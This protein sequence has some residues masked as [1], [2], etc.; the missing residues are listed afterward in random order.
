MKMMKNVLIIT[1]IPETIEGFLLPFVEYFQ[2][3][4]WQL[5]G[6]AHNISNRTRC[7]NIFDRV[8]DIEWSRN[9]LDPRNLLMA[10]SKIKKIVA[11]EKYDIVH[12]HTPIAAFVTRYA[13]KDI[14]KQDKLKVIYTA[15]GFHFHRGGN[16][17]TNKLF[18]TLE[19]MAAKWTDYLIV[20]NKE[21]KTAAKQYRLLQPEKIYY[22]PGIGVDTQYYHPNKVAEADILEVHRELGLAAN[23]ELLVSVAEFTVNKR[24]QDIIQALARLNRPQVH[25]A[26]AGDGPMKK[27]TERLAVELGLQS[28]VHFLGFRSDI[29]TLIRAAKATLLTSQRE[30]LPRSIMEALCLETPVIGTEIRG[31]RDLLAENCGLLVKVGDIE[32]LAGAM[33]WIIDNPQAAQKMGKRGR[34]KMAEYDVREIIRQYAEIYNRAFL[35]E[36]VEKKAKDRQSIINK[37]SIIN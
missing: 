26:F 34:E 17:L 15:H 9:P 6:M 25:I 24:H 23:D 20:I 33:A 14:R 1:T 29:P 32:G 5:D 16:F 30:G 13:L 3:Q 19:R 4:G 18:L 21:D 2:D 31:T 7:L 22:T 35:E 11:Q 27:A 37:K 36:Q 8:W 12:V 10:S 28:Q